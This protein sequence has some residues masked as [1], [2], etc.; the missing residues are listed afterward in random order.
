M[1][2]KKPDFG[3]MRCEVCQIEITRHSLMQK[4]CAACSEVKDLERKRVWARDH[5]AAPENQQRWRERSMSRTRSQGVEISNEARHAISWMGDSPD[6]I[7]MVRVAFPFDWAM[8]KNHLLSLAAHGHVHL[9][10]ESRTTRDSLILQLNTAL[11]G[12]PIVQAKLWLDLLV[13]K[14]NHK[15]DAVNVVDFV[16][17]AVKVATGL[18]DRWYSIRRLD[19]EIVK[20]DPKVYIGLGQDTDE[21]QQVCSYCGRILP[22]SMFTKNVRGRMGIG[23]ECRDCKRR[24]VE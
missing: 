22:F 13:Q 8:S 14:P 11:V 4:Y 23:R 5:P 19:W 16:C 21:Q 17:D 18:D 24:G 3:M 9:R 12:T 2:R 7:W 6:L 1:D 20:T 10:E 15:G